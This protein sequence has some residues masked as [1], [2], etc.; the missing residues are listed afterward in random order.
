M[1]L[2]V[3]VWAVC[4]A[5]LVAGAWAGRL[6]TTVTEAL[7]F[8][9]GA[10]CVYLVVRQSVWNFPFGIATSALYL[11][12]FASSRLFGDAALQGVYIVLNAHGWYWWL[13]GGADHTP[14]EVTRASRT[15]VA[16]TTA[17]VVAG[18]AALAYALRA[19]SGSAP[20][21][22]AL[23]TTMS[24]AAQFLLNRKVIENW[25]VWIAADVIYVYLYTTRGLY[26]TAI[27]YF[28]FLCMCIAGVVAWRRSLASMAE[29]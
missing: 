29:R 10:A 27:L 21:L 18:T 1:G 25:Y 4:S 11:F 16:G 8:V 3:A 20:V 22:D 14:P 24:L 23:T 13:R 2:E 17:F 19:A 12:V 7:G 15:M 6:E 26:L 5:A 9:T 28:V